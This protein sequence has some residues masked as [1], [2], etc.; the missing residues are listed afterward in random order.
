MFWTKPLPCKR[1]MLGVGSLGVGA[2]RKAGDGEDDVGMTGP[3]DVRGSGRMGRASEGME[4]FDPRGDEEDGVLLKDWR[5]AKEVVLNGGETG[6]G[7]LLLEVI[8]SREGVIGRGAFEEREDGRGPGSGV[9]RPLLTT[10]PGGDTALS[11]DGVVGR[12]G[13]RPVRGLVSKDTDFLT[14]PVG[15]LIVL[16]RVPVF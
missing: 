16:S 7:G 4:T 15:V 8:D 13:G 3:W 5:E 6:G 1:L 14:D 2:F 12:E 11:R 9:A 10:M